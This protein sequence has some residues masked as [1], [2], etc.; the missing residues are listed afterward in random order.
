MDRSRST[1]HLRDRFPTLWLLYCLSMESIRLSGPAHGIVTKTV[2]NLP[3]GGGGPEGGWVGRGLLE[4]RGW[5]VGGPE[6]G[7]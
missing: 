3:R 2:Q 7:G 6:V 4:S 5:W 1:F